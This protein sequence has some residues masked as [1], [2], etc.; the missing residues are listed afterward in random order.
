MGFI[1]NVIGGVKNMIKNF[2]IIIC[3]LST[4]PNRIN[5]INAGFNNIFKGFTTEFEA[6][7]KSFYQGTSSIGLLG[8]YIGELISTYMMCGFKFAGNFF[9]C[10]FY[11]IIDIILY[12]L[13]L[14]AIIILW[15]F[16]S[17]LDIDLYFIPQNT[18]K[19]LQLINDFLFPYL[20][21]HIIHWPKKIRE[22]CYL[23]K[24]LKTQAVDKTATNVKVTFKE[25]IPNNFGKSKLLF[26]RGRH[27]FEEMFKLYARKPSEVH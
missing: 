7:G 18:Y 9:D 8:L 21:F 22:D 13:Y 15:A 10:I 6:I 2:K 26:R 5:N 4:V 27:Q 25:K 19:G 14:P 12:I 11:Y 1:Q 23:C 17:F 3:F 24:R 20:G 16:D